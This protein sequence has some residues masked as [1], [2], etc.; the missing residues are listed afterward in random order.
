MSAYPIPLSADATGTLE[1]SRHYPE[2]PG[3]GT[4]WITIDHADPRITITHEL[5]KRIARGECLPYAKIWTTCCCSPSI[6]C[7][8]FQGAKL[9]VRDRDRKVVYII[10]EP[11][12]TSWCWPA[13][14]P[15]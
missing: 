2:T 9:E 15:D 1:V 10:G 6:R 7:I 8:H 13:E 4:G 14:W 12:C 5:V 11:D 3:D